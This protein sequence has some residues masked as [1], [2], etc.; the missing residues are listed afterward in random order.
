MN[1]MTLIKQHEWTMLF[2]QKII[3]KPKYIALPI[4]ALL[5][6]LLGNKLSWGLR[7]RDNKA[8]WGTNILTINLQFIYHIV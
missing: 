3:E 6:K 4:V 5:Y 2:Y 7:D 8:R 1:N